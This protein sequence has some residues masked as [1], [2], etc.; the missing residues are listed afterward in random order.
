MN[1]T[2]KATVALAVVAAGLM[3]GI[4]YA[5]GQD[6]D[7]SRPQFG[8]TPQL[9][10][11]GP[12]PHYI[13]VAGP[14]GEIAGYVHADLFESGG[15][16]PRSPEEALEW[17]RTI[18]GLIYEVFDTEGKIVGYFATRVGFVDAAEKDALVRD[19]YR[20]LNAPKPK[21]DPND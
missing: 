14:R 5:A 4:V 20:L 21:V 18:K 2:P 12:T 8:T 3:G 6:V 15:P 11:G 10:S 17:S 9:R 7:R 13:A 16:E 19:G 1:R